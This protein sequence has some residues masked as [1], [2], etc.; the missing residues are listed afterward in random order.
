M[1]VNPS[2]PIVLKFLQDLPTKSDGFSRNI[3]HLFEKYF[4]VSVSLIL[5]YHEDKLTGPRT[6]SGWSYIVKNLN[7]NQIR[8]YFNEF[9]QSDIF[10][11]RQHR[12]E[13]VASLTEIFPEQGADQSPYY[14]YLQS[15]GISYQ[16][17][18]FLRNEQKRLAT[19][20]LF[21]SE[22][23][24]DFS[25]E[26]LECFRI[27]EPFI[28]KQ[29]LQMLEI[30]QAHSL[31]KRFS[32]Y[33][34][35]LSLGVALLD[36]DSKILQ[37]NNAF[38]EYAKYIFENGTIEDN[39]VTRGTVDSSPEHLWGQKLLNYFGAKVISHP[40]RIRIECLLYLFQ[41]HTKEIYCQS[42]L[43]I[44]AIEHQYLVF[45]VRQEKIRSAEILAA[46]NL[47]TPREMSVIGYLASGM[48]N[49]EIA[50]AMSISQFTVKTHLQNI[51]AKCNVSGRNELLA[52]LK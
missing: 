27:L 8:P 41:F 14:Q 45:L 38:H 36:R 50:D 6:A 29:Y 7:P 47:L 5:L 25:P 13:R 9:F 43:N 33:F 37:A 49:T 2:Y 28:T 24:G 26:E 18:I 48:N 42:H 15:L 30:N 1:P 23:D 19:I 52:K 16:A 44:N 11:P 51:Y 39:F 17:C 31:N 10:S 46:L 22:D 34:S 35:D 12:L 40:N 21:R 32:D 4:R 3:L 20:S